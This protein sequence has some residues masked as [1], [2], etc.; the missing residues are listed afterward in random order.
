M[1]FNVKKLLGNGV[2]PDTMA[3]GLKEAIPGDIADLGG[4]RP[5]FTGKH[6]N[7]NVYQKLLIQHLVPLV[8]KTYIS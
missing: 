4:P 6:L 3:K 2:D 8:L 5:I 7:A 1:V